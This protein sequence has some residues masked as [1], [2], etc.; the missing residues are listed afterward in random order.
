MSK[1][2]LKQ[3]AASAVAV[4]DA[5]SSSADSSSSESYRYEDSE[6]VRV[7]AEYDKYCN[8]VLSGSEDIEDE[9]AQVARPHEYSTDEESDVG[10][11]V[12]QVLE[13]SSDST[14]QSQQQ[15]I[16]VSPLKTTLAQEVGKAIARCKKKIAKGETH[17]MASAVLEGIGIPLPLGERAM[18]HGARELHVL[19]QYSEYPLEE[20][21]A[22][23]N[24]RANAPAWVDVPYQALHMACAYLKEGLSAEMVSPAHWL[25]ALDAMYQV[26]SYRVNQLQD[27]HRQNITAKFAVILTESVSKSTAERVAHRVG[28]SPLKY[29]MPGFL[30][31][32][33]EHYHAKKLLSKE[34]ISDSA[35]DEV[36]GLFYDA[37]DLSLEV[38]WQSRSR[39]RSNA[40]GPAL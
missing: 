12:Q 28:K 3:A 21:K 33:L 22:V 18:R 24:I 5:G 29:V 10:D 27:I 4:T 15:G 9:A 30:S 19:M 36:L 16:D 1:G 39:S 23:K 13:V 38:E 34:A 11:E 20:C 8:T 7:V 2:S 17:M 32:T 37:P 6:L 40:S 25:Q 26:L 14:A 35:F 31:D